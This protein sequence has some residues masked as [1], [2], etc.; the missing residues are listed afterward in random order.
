MFVPRWRATP[1]EIEA[2]PSP[3][4]HRRTRPP[5]TPPNDTTP[6]AHAPGVVE[7]IDRSDYLHLTLVPVRLN[8]Q[9]GAGFGPG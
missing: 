8:A 4:A 7:R 5:V 3:P 2:E 9:Y 6:G 1:P